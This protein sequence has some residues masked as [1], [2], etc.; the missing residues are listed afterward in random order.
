LRNVAFRNS[1]IYK[2][3]EKQKMKKKFLGLIAV[4]AAVVVFAA[5]SRPVE[6]DSDVTEHGNNRF[7]M[8]TVAFGGGPF[9]VYLQFNADQSELLS[10]E[11][12]FAG[13]TAS[14]MP[15]VRDIMALI[16]EHQTTEGIN[17]STGSTITADAVVEVVET[18]FAHIGF[19]AGEA[20]EIVMPEPEGIQSLGGNRFSMEAFGWGSGGTNIIRVYL[21]F[22]DDQDQLL[23]IESDFE[24]ETPM[25]MGAVREMIDQIVAAQSTVGID[26]EAGSTVTSD[27]VVGI[28][29]A[30]FNHINFVPA[31]QPDV[32]EPDNG[33]EEDVPPTEDT[34]TPPTEGGTTP[35][36]QGRFIPGPRQASTNNNYS[37]QPGNEGD[38][39]PTP[40]VVEVVFGDDA[41][42][43]WRV[44]SHGDS[45]PWVT[46]ATNALNARIN[47]ATGPISTDT[48]ADATYTS[49]GIIEAVNQAI[50]AATR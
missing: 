19:V 41:V 23:S 26:T 29:D 16:V 18:V 36:A 1:T 6:V 4:V 48:V 33:Y 45:G 38:L 2:K 13:E 9:T 7:S 49:R 24:G 42:I 28:V 47:G 8:E 12:D 34:T 10:I 25:F 44:V 14:F 27:A 43:S 50:S 46:A 22:N 40:L 30:I 11:S 15:A 20:A 3:G 35:A 39:T 37:N 21:Q 32:V 17:T 5:C 31:E